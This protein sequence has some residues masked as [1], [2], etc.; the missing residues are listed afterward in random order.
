MGLLY[1]RNF[2]GV[3]ELNTI[4][5]KFEIIVSSIFEQDNPESIMY[6]DSYYFSNATHIFNH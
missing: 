6:S 4:L 3:R 2:F 1:S 5:E